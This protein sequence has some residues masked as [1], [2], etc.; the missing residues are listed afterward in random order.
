MHNIT[1]K[2]LKVCGEKVRR[3]AGPREEGGRGAALWEW[4]IQGYSWYL[5]E[6]GVNCSCIVYICVGKLI[7]RDIGCC[8]SH[9]GKGKIEMKLTNVIVMIIR[10]YLL[11]YLFLEVICMW[12][13]MTHWGLH[14]SKTC[15]VEKPQSFT[16]LL[17]NLK[18]IV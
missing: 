8:M 10:C 9:M 5:Y 11:V 18:F 15:L 17:S 7:E 16:W 3:E 12:S 2:G 6:P 14:V 13:M 4:E 1:E